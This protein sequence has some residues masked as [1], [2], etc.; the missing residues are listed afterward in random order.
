MR[1]VR[2]MC[3]RLRIALLAF[4]RSERQL[5]PG[6]FAGAMVIAA[7]IGGAISELLIR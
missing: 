4:W 1:P 6:R 7:S 2:D 5:A 3:R